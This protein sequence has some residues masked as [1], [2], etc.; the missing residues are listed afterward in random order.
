MKLDDFEK[1]RLCG[2][3]GAGMSQRQSAIYLGFSPSAVSKA[4]RRDEKFADDVARAMV[5]AKFQP[6]Y[7]VIKASERSW[8][9]AV[10][11]YQ[12][13]QPHTDLT[14]RDARRAARRAEKLARQQVERQQALDQQRKQ[15]S[16]DEFTEVCRSVGMR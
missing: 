12:N 4:L 11:L 9:A 16:M 1:A 2:L 8:R 15:Q 6:L 5:S 3:I 13:A 10:W 14:E 7:K